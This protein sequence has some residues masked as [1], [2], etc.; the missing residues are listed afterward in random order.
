[1]LENVH[2]SQGSLQKL[3]C[4]PNKILTIFIRDF[5][6]FPVAHPSDGFIDVV[7]QEIVRRLACNFSNNIKKANEFALDWPLPG[8][9]AHG[10]C[11]EWQR[12]LPRTRTPSILFSYSLLPLT[13]SP[14]SLSSFSF[15]SNITTK[16]TP[17]ASPHTSPQHQKTG[18]PKNTGSRSMAS[19][20]RYSSS[21]WS[22]I[23]RLG[24]C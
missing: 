10:R 4:C 19:I 13:S 2:G 23:R 11:R 12:L 16:P 1:M 7:A 17:T 22:V 9:F 18:N 3:G 15:H 5:M 20:T 24:R 8:P 14:P 21:R 6:Q